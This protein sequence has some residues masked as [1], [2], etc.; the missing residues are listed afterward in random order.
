[1]ERGCLP[2]TITLDQPDPAC[3]LDCVPRQGRAAQ[4]AVV[5]SNSFGFGGINASLVL[6]R[7]TGPPRGGGA[8]PPST[9]GLAA[10]RKTLTPHPTEG[11]GTGS[12]AFC[13]AP[14][15]VTTTP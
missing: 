2:P 3:D 4:P 14:A 8:F 13:S 12:L 9:R 15:A 11:R 1:M 7:G 10:E 5:V 6:R